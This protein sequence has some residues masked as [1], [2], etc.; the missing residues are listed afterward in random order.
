MLPPSNTP[1]NKAGIMFTRRPSASRSRPNGICTYRLRP[2][3][4]VRSIKDL[5]EV[6]VGPSSRGTLHRQLNHGG[7]RFT[8][9][10][11]P[12]LLVAD[13]ADQA[14]LIGTD[15]LDK[16]IG[17]IYPTDRVRYWRSR[18]H[19]RNTRDTC[20]SRRPRWNAAPKCKR[21]KKRARSKKSER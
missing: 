15:A 5:K 8:R 21:E 19:Q 3:E 6:I 18:G 11:L 1:R 4:R 2:V 20:P 12:V 13:L 14:R 16:F 10:D 17:R 9:L 7:L